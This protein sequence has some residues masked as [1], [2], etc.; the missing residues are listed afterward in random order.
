MGTLVG[1][2]V[3]LSPVLWHAFEEGNFEVKS[4]G[5]I[6]H[7]FEKSDIYSLGVTLISATLLLRNE[8]IGM[9]R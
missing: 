9:N 1:T 3:F 6:K 4:I 7:N 8:V 5:K 2:P